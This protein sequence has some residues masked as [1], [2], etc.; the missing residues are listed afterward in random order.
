MQKANIELRLIDDGEIATV[1]GYYTAFSKKLFSGRTL[2]G[3]SFSIE[4][5]ITSIPYLAQKKQSFG[6]QFCQRRARLTASIAILSCITM[7]FTDTA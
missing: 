3:L 4:F 7:L 6:S 2:T 5:A 1:P